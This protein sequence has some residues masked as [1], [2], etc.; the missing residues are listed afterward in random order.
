MEH[1]FAAQDW[2]RAA[3]LLEQHAEPML[4]RGEFLMLHRWLQVLPREVVRQQPHLLLAHAWAQCRLDPRQPDAVEAMLHDAEAV[5]DPCLG[6]PV[7]K[8]AEPPALQQQRAELRGK[9]AA[10]RASVAG[11]RQDIPRRI[12]LAEEAL[13]YLPADNLFWR[14]NP[15]VDRGLALDAAGEAGAASQAFTEAIDLCRVAG[16]SYAAMIATM[17]LARVRATQ[18]RLH[19]A[20]ELHQRAL[21]MAA[22]QGWGQLPMVGLPHVFWGT[23]LYEWNDLPSAA[24]HLLEGITL[25]SSGEQRILLEGYATLARVKQAQGDVASALDA[26]RH[27]EEVAQT[28][29]APWAVPLVRLWLAQ[30]QV[31]RADRWVEQAGLQTDDELVSQRELEYMTLARVQLA[32]G[33]SAEALPVL[34]RLLQAAEAA[35]RLGSVIEVLLLQA[36]GLQARGD[37]ARAI[38]VLGRAL[39]L[40]EPEGYVRVFADEGAPMAALLA[41][42]V[43]DWGLENGTH[44]HDVRAYAHKLLAV[45]K[46]EGIEPQA[47]PHLLS[48]EPRALALNGEVL[49]ERELEV[50]RLLAVGR[51]NQ[52]IADELIIAV[53]TV[54]RHVSNI[55]DKLQ[56][57]S[58][59]AAVTYA[60]ELNLV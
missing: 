3:R 45:L 30:G 52:A 41:R 29:A 44:G 15:M 26:I 17:H 60:R 59:L 9:L 47:D 39:L 55:M 13:T 18:G 38:T 35:E 25:A 16:Y 11:N 46:A 33:K 32:Q 21:H 34:E 51:S 53:G 56:V 57:Q 27:A 36:L 23:L 22:A 8:R 20:A 6:P 40:A 24:Q 42:G 4:M 19:A 5:L 12:A 31:D 58:R 2:E 49:T 48:S 43:S 54:K 28:S 37:H 10:V 14:I 50:L 7:D 1:V